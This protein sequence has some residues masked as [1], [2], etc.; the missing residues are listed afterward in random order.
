MVWAG[1]DIN[2]QPF[3]ISVQLLDVHKPRKNSD[4]ASLMS[5]CQIYWTILTDRNFNTLCTGKK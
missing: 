2:E 3:V 5:I 1:A 4:V